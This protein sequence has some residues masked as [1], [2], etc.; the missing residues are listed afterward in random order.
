MNVA[1][2]NDMTLEQVCHVRL[3]MKSCTLFL[4]LQPLKGEIK[5][6]DDREE[7][8]NKTMHTGSVIKKSSD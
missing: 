6:I 1:I 8:N 4:I 3:V 2:N 5:I 7:Y